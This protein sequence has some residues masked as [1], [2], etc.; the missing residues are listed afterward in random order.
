V[1]MAVKKVR[2]Q[3]RQHSPPFHAAFLM[4]WAMHWEKSPKEPPLRKRAMLK[5]GKETFTKGL[6]EKVLDLLARIGQCSKPPRFNTTSRPGLRGVLRILVLCSDFLALPWGHFSVRFLSIDCNGDT[7]RCGQFMN[8]GDRFLPLRLL[9]SA[10]TFCASLITFVN[11]SRV[12]F[13]KS[14]SII[15]LVYSKWPIRW[16]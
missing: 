7:D 6:D 16:A 8:L 4:C 13:A 12:S 9:L 15:Y 3:H 5:G 14:V 1:D 11:S 10:R 2:C